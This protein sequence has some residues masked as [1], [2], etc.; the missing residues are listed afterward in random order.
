MKPRPAK[1]TNHPASA[2]QSPTPA[3]PRAP[4]WHLLFAVGLLLAAAAI[5]SIRPITDSDFWHHITLGRTYIETGHLPHTDTLSSTAS[6]RPW[7]SSGWL[8]SIWLYQAYHNNPEGGPNAVVRAVVTL[9]ALTMLFF[10]IRRTRNFALPATLAIVTLAAAAPRFLPR[11]DIFSQLMLPL[12][13]I[14]LASYQQRPPAPGWRGWLRL[15]LC[16][17]LFFAWANLHML[18]PIGLAILAIFCTFRVT[19]R[20]R[21]PGESSLLWPA[22]TVVSLIACFATPYGWRAFWFIVENAQLHNASSR[23]NELKPLW[24]ALAEPG[25][26]ASFAMLALWAVAAVYT[27]WLGNVRSR[28]SRWHWA[29]GAFLLAL[30]LI[31]RRQIALAVPGVTVL[32]FATFDSLVAPG[33]APRASRRRPLRPHLRALRIW[34]SPFSIVIPAAILSGAYFYLVMAGALPDPRNASTLKPTR[35]DCNWFP[36][37][38]VKFLKQNPPPQRL[39]HDLYTGGFLAYHLAPRTPVFIDGRLEVYNN[40]TFDDYFAPPEGRMAVLDLLQKYDVKSVLVDWRAAATQPAHTALML[41]TRA[42]W[43]LCWFSDNY[44]LFVKDDTPAGQQ[45]VQDH[46]Y[47]YLNP[48]TPE[49]FLQAL[50]NPATA[51]A[52]KAEAQ[53][54]STQDPTGHLATR[55]TEVSQQY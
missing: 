20:H 45:Y 11:P 5:F 35:V 33:S 38:A 29:S 19:S 43:H 51:Q 40:G 8:P 31:Q 2:A 17:V 22:V 53:R 54:A 14:L 26:A 34:A 21:L 9:L 55:A 16:P 39:F 18:F 48:L 7:V 37:K 42:G 50:Q 36:C 24:T 6:G 10:G 47:K 44:A 32:I 15:S 52:A 23:I 49:P 4:S 25:A 30:A 13:L 1:P 28:A 27:A 12:L 46:G 41:S 3:P